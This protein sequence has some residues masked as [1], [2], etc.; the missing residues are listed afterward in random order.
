MTEGVRPVPVPLSP[1]VRKLFE[2][3]NFAH[4]ATLMADGSPQV[5]V[6]WVDIEGD[7]IL[8]NTAEGRAKP[9]NV[10]RD[11]RVAISI[12]HPSGYPSAT[13]RGKVVELTHDGADAHIDKLA[14]KYLGQDTY[15][16]RNPAEQ[17]VIIIIDPEHA[18]GMNTD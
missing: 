12:S 15:P 3:P 1:G 13:V 4:F 2:D 6:V 10:R 16:F 11:S 18:A 9:R 14:K 5:T 7:R 8:I 17:R